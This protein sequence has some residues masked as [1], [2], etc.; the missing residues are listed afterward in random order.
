MIGDVSLFIAVKVKSR[1]SLVFSDLP[2]LWGVFQ[3][4]DKLSDEF[5]GFK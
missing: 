4:Y 5:P 2:L 3:L 1:S